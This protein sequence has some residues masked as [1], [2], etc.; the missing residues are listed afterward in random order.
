KE[1]ARVKVLENMQ[2]KI[3]EAETLLV[4]YIGGNL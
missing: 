4:E 2:I 1:P 3:N